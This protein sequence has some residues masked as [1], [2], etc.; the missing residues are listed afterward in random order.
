MKVEFSTDEI[1]V[2]AD[3]ILTGLTNDVKLNRKDAAALRRWRNE[4]ITPKSAEM[5]LL[6]EKVNHEL[7]H[8]HD[9]SQKSGIVKPDWA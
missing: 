5:K 9:S 8:T 3:T 7:Q 4:T 1:I 6:T 2:M